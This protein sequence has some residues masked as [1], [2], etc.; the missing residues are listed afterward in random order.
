MSSSPSGDTAGRFGGARN[1]NFDTH[2]K[3]PP[4][5]NHVGSS[6]DGQGFG[7]KDTASHILFHSPE[8]PDDDWAQKSE[9]SAMPRVK[10]ASFLR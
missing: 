6:P 8:I 1:G 9:A 5:D 7:T 2:I 10:E 3:V 4:A